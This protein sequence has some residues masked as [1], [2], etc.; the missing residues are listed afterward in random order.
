MSTDSKLKILREGER[1]VQQ[2]KISLAINEYL[3]IVKIDPEDVLTINTIG[4]L[5]LRQGRVGEAN[6]LFLQVAQNYTSNNFLLKSI[7]V[8]KKIL[9]TDPQNL[10]VNSLIASLFA[11]QGMN[12]DARNQYAFIAELC[13]REG[14]L[15]DSLDA[16]EKVVEI[17]PSNATIQLKLAENYL[18]QGMNDRAHRFFVGAARSQIKSGNVS[19]SMQS[20]RRALDLKPE[21]PEALQGLLE[22]ALPT[23][24]VG[25]VLKVAE[26]FLDGIPEDPGLAEAVGR[27]YLASGDLEQ[28]DL[29][30]RQMLKTDESRY[31][32][33]LPLSSA[34]LDAAN[35]DRALSC[36]DPVVPVLISRRETRKCIDAY[37]QILS[38]HPSHVTTLRKLADIFSATNDDQNCIAAL[39]NLARHFENEKNPAEA[40]DPLEKIL[41]MIPDSEPHRKRHREAFEQAFPGTAY[42]LPRAVLEAAEFDSSRNLEPAAGPAAFA[43]K[44]SDSS[45]AAIVEI[46]LLL[47]YG[48]NE[49]A[50]ELLRTLESKNP[51]DKEVR[52]R[53]ATIHRES[54]ELRLAAEQYVLL[55]ALHRKAGD[56][57]AANSTWDEARSLDSAWVN[58]DLDVVSFAQKHGINLDGLR[59][60]ESDRER[61]GN[62]EVDL[63]G[64]LS[65]IFFKDIQPE[66]DPDEIPDADEPDSIADEFS[67]DI[68]HSSVPAS[69]EEQLQEV[70]FYVRLGFQDEARAKLDEI[71]AGYPD[72]PAL[73][74]RYEQLNRE[75]A[76]SVALDPSLSLEPSIEEAEKDNGKPEPSVPGALILEQASA[77]SSTEPQAEDELQPLAQL[78]I[79]EEWTA[80]PADRPEA[81]DHIEEH[82]RQATWT[83]SADMVTPAS[84]A[85]TEATGN[86]MF[87]DL[88]EE[89]NLLTDREIE[90]EDFETHFGLGIAY[91]EMGLIDDAVKEF[92]S[93]L[94][95][96]NSSKSPKE[97]IQCCGM[98]S[99]CFLEKGMPRSAIRW[100][101]T[102][103]ATS[104]I[105]SHESMALRYDMGVAHS[106]AGDTG[107]ALE[108]F[109]V[110]FNIDPGYRDVA[111]RIDDLK[112]GN[113]RHAP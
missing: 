65:E 103:L 94:K 72:H 37:N 35:P 21:S 41:H 80:Q 73:E 70:D 110:I 59:A 82:G 55:S 50:L 104:E 6:Q 91:R 39:E 60:D 62:L 90:R 56:A 108:C 111:Q 109:G 18:A 19:A 83:G 57:E 34:F 12:V 7:A 23:G 92:Q 5:Y 75:P 28:A 102:G 10:E 45:N 14:K 1:Y 47:N 51:M 30:F 29:H 46:D 100:C 58:Q 96:L 107:Q 22:T 9:K 64:D 66:V 112:S 87:A 101:Q 15:Q 93:A 76:Q 68:P 3:K 71:A 2:G 8:Y 4:D 78:S 38:R 11:R 24:E 31:E 52:F 40:L 67:L 16:Y 13:A 43:T 88:L 61:G 36:L 84:P 105:S 54:G 27:A 32:S 74:Q 77:P 33:F 113:Q 97:V 26:E 95:G 48:M 49:K 44:G 106:S 53:L 79:N 81:I 86:S 85:T 63:S 25:A 99:T 42:K 98:L 89:L 17:D 69:V 20:F